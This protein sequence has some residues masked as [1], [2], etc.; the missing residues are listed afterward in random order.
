MIGFANALLTV[1]Y[2]VHKI[3]IGRDLFDSLELA[4]VPEHATKGKSV[5]GIH[6]ST[7]KIKQAILSQISHL[8]LRIELTKTQTVKLKFPQKYKAK[9]QKGQRVPFNLQSIVIEELNNF[10]KEGHIQK[11]LKSSFLQP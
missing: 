8:V 6:N 1:V 2:L 3:I 9:N 11:L 10:Q 7:S 4:I 5:N